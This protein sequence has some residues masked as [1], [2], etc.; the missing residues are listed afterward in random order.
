[1][2][3]HEL[4]VRTKAFAHRCV[5][6]SIAIPKST[7]GKHIKSQL[8]RYSTSVA[9]NYRAAVLAQSTASFTAKLSIVLEEIDESVFWLEFIKDEDLLSQTQSR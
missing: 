7:L 1:M 3:S 9:A 6:L 5:K 8:I 4:K 2:D